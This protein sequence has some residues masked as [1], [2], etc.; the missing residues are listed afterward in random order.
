MYS[1]YVKKCEEEQ[2]SP[3][4]EHFYRYVFKTKF[5]LHF[6]IPKKD[7]CKKCDIFKIKI[8][9]PELSRDELLQQKI[10]HEL[11][12]RK[13]ELARKCMNTDATNVKENPESYVCSVDLQKALPFPISVSDAYYKRNMYCYNFGVHNLEAEVGV[14]YLWNETIASRGAQQVS[15]CIIKHLKLNA[16]NKKHVIIYSDTCTG[17]NWNIRM[18]LA[19]KRLLQSEETEIETI[20]QKFLVSGLFY[21]MMQILV[22]L[23]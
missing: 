21:R 11:H 10:A 3:V 23:N 6:Y 17:Q 16:Q 2:R 8:S 15:S 14:F 19:I 9:N 18:A 1:L 4:K 22:Q 13:A 5:N 7:T 20:D 12:L